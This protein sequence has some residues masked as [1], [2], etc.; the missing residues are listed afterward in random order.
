MENRAGTC[1]NCGEPMV[2]GRSIC[3]RCGFRLG[4]PSPWLILARIVLVLA[5]LLIAVPAAL[6]G[7]CFVVF[8]VGN[9]MR[10]PTGLLI[11]F[12]L[13][14]LAAALLWGAVQVFRR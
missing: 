5:C 11:G 13:L 12:A 2:E 1:P 9:G 7:G 10:D 8:G 4:K 6:A 14:T 3:P